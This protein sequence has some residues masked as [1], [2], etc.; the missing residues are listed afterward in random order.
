VSEGPAWEPGWLDSARATLTRLLWRGV[1]AQHLVATMKLVD[2]LAEQEILERL[3]DDSKPPLPP[4]ARGLHYLLATP[5]RYAS[6]HA[7]RFRAAGEPGL[8]YGAESVLTA[9]SEVG[10]WRWRFV[11]DSAGLD[12]REVVT[13]HT[14]FQALVAGRAIDLGESPWNAAKLWWAHPTDYG[15]CHRLAEQAR[16]AGLQWIRYASVRHPAGHCAAVLDPTALALPSPLLQQSWVCK[17]GRQQV[18]LIH[19]QDR[20]TLRFDEKGLP[21]H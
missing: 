8:W 19:D 14:F 5:F 12:Q 2:T 13:E 6:A 3:I 9:A 7:S 1:E 10:H 21:V 16:D 18:L 15:E 11:A 4:G 17:A 20:L